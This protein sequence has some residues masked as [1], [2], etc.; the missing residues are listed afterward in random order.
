MSVIQF[1][2]SKSRV[3]YPDDQ[4][5]IVQVLGSYIPEHYALHVVDPEYGEIKP[6]KYLNKWETQLAVVELK[7]DADM[8]GFK[9]EVH[10]ISEMVSC[11]IFANDN[12]ESA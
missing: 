1:P 4:T 12:R 6:T 5:V 11:L 10:E 3:V 2:P 9:F 7:D 8:R